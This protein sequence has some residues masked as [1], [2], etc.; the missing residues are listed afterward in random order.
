MIQNDPNYEI[1]FFIEI[2]DLKIYHRPSFLEF[3]PI[4]I[5]H[6]FIEIRLLLF[7]TNGLR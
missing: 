6:I 3:T 1:I 4:V 5:I 2:R 7:A